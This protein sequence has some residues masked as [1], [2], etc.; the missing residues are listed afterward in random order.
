MIFFKKNIRSSYESDKKH[1][2]VSK[3]IY[4]LVYNPHPVYWPTSP[5]SL[6]LGSSAH[7]TW[8]HFW[9]LK[10]LRSFPSWYCLHFPISAKLFSHMFTWWHAGHSYFSW[11]WALQD[12]F[13]DRSLRMPPP[14]P[15]LFT[16][17]CF[18][19]ITHVYTWCLG[20][21][22]FGWNPCCTEAPQQ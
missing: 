21:Y 2:M 9:P 4:S 5:T 20:I 19:I 22:V 6:P 12:T 15:S 18:S 7:V 14:A 8:L 11:L 16:S 3:T 13:P 10:T 17:L 1:L